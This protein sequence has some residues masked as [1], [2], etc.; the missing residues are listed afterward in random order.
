MAKALTYSIT[1]ICLSI[2][3]GGQTTNGRQALRRS[4]RFSGFGSLKV[5]EPIRLGG[6]ISCGLKVWVGSRQAGRRLI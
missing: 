4:N 1:T 5:R 2:A 3:E 6:P